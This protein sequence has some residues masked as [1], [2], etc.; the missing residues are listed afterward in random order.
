[1]KPNYLLSNQFKK[2]GWIIFIP[3]MILGLLFF[4]FQFQPKFLDIRV[5][6]IWESTMVPWDSW[7]NFCVITQ[8]NAIDEIIGILLIISLFFVAFSKEKKEDEFISKIRLESLL[9]A[10]YINCATLIFS[11]LFV[12]GGAGFWV[13]VFNVFTI[14]IFFIIRFN[15]AITESRKSAGNEK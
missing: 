2:I 12:Y 15:W 14:L 9:W 8:T 11:I 3:S 13:L 10:T 6:A 5:F 4:L 7:N 1:M